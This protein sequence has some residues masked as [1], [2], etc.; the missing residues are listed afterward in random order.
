MSAAID[1]ELRS[2][3]FP[4]EPFARRERVGIVL[5]CE[6]G[7]NLIARL[8]SVSSLFCETSSFS[9]KSLTMVDVGVRD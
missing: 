7:Q 4:C 5:H 9:P 2:L 6:D 3:L 8:S 1:D